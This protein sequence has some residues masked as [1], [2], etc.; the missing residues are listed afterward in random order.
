[1]VAQVTDIKKSMALVMELVDRDNWVVFHKDRE[2]VHTMKARYEVKMK[3]MVN[4]RN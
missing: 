1:M 4:S 3:T 2:F